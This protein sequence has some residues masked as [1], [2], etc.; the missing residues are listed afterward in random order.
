MDLIGPFDASS[1]G[2]CYTFTVIC[3][4]TCNPF[5]VTLKIKATIEVV[6]RCIDKMYAKFEGSTKDS[7]LQ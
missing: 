7:L 1:N 6:H 5:C 4:L 3:M 2:H